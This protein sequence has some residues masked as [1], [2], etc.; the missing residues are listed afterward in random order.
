MAFQKASNIRF[1]TLNNNGS[2]SVLVAYELFDTELSDETFFVE[3]VITDKDIPGL[4][5]VIERGNLTSR[6]SALLGFIRPK[7]KKDYDIW[8]AQRAKIVNNVKKDQLEVAN[9]FGI[10][11]ITSV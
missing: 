10:E 5:N 3:Y 1:E 9:E 6:K 2:L 4:K 8:V 11:E 7:L